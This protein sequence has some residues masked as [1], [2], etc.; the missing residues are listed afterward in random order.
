MSLKAQ[1]VFTETYR[2]SEPAVIYGK[3]LTK[4]NWR[5]TGQVNAVTVAFE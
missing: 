5:L 3:F 2:N 4:M 1:I